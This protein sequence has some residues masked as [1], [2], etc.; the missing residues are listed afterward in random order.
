M[1]TIL[2][3]AGASVL[4]SS[5]SLE[6][7]GHAA[8]IG[9]GDL[10]VTGYAST[11]AFEALDEFGMSSDITAELRISKVLRGHA[12][13]HVL[14]IR[15]IAHTDWPKGLELRFHLRRS[16]TATWLVCKEGNGLGYICE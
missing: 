10:V 8:R 3:L 12:P 7:K 5:A 6:A 9:R 13:S 11:R 14:T 4:L 15:Y 16:S 1:N 2:C